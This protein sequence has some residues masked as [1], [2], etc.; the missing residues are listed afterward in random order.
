MMNIKI[1]TL[2]L[3]LRLKKKDLVKNILLQ[4]KIGVLSLQETEIESSFDKNMLRIP[5]FNLELESNS[6]QS[7]VGFLHFE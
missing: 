5:G 3:C 1:A 6:R 2:N 7:R 4:N